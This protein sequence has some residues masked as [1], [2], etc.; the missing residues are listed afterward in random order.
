MAVVARH[1][2]VHIFFVDVGGDD[3]FLDFTILPIRGTE[4]I[5]VEYWFGE[6]SCSISL[7]RLDGLFYVDP[8]DGQWFVFPRQRPTGFERVER[9]SDKCIDSAGHQRGII[10]FTRHLQWLF[11]CHR[12]A[13]L[14]IPPKRVRQE[15]KIP[16][17]EGTP[18]Y[19]EIR[20]GMMVVGDRFS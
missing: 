2:M 17:V 7:H 12:S 9:M 15:A 18:I 5:Q 8:W 19:V 11:P 16:A 20:I 10:T 4:L 1:S 14:R 13:L 3:S 6:L